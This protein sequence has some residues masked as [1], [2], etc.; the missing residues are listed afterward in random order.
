M[1]VATKATTAKD[2]NEMVWVTVSLDIYES[3]A[4]R[5]ALQVV[6]ETRFRL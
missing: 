3:A 4:L 6:K 2:G 5:L 1:T